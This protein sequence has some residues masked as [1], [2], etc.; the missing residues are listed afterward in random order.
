MSE[1]LQDAI[2]KEEKHLRTRGVYLLIAALV[3]ALSLL[4]TGCGKAASDKIAEK[5][6]EEALE[7]A[8]GDQAQVDI[9]KDGAVE[10]KTKEGAVS[11][12]GSDYEWPSQLPED[13]PRLTEGKIVSI[14]ENNNPQGENSVFIGLDNVTAAALNAYQDKLTAAGWTIA[15][16]SNDTGGFSILAAKD[17]RNIA[18]NFRSAGDRG[19][20]G[21]ITYS[22]Q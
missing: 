17:Q 3:L 13:V 14:V 18:V 11:V 7:K 19:F 5:A 12:G 8:T 4:I 20:S 1:L 22:E 2:L 6:T 10:V 9:G 15:L 16:S 21:G